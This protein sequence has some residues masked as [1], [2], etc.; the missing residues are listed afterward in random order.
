MSDTP[1]IAQYRAIKKAH[2]DHLLFYRMGDFYELF[3]DDAIQGA[4]LLNITLTHRGQSNGQPIPMAGV[5]YHAAK[6]YFKRLV[7]LGHTFAIC[8]QVGPVQKNSKDPV[9]REVTQ[10][11]TPG[12]VLDEAF[13]ADDQGHILMSV[14]Q[15]HQQYAIATLDL[16]RGLIEYST[17]HG[18]AEL[19]RLLTLYQP[20]EL[21]ISETQPHLSQHGFKATKQPDWFFYPQ[22]NHERIC[23]QF[24]VNQLNAFGLTCAHGAIRVIGALLNYLDLTHQQSPPRIETLRSIQDDAFVRLDEATLKHMVYG[25]GPK[26]QRSLFHYLNQTKTPM[27]GRLLKRWLG[28]PTR[29]PETLCMRQACIQDLMDTSILAYLQ[30]ALINCHDLERCTMRLNKLAITPTECLKLAKT[31]RQLPIII[32]QTM[33]LP[34]MQCMAL[35]AMDDWVKTIEATLYQPEAIDDDFK[36]IIKPG[37]SPELDALR[38]TAA[39]SAFI[40]QYEH[41]QQQ[42]VDNL[43]IK[44][45]YNRIQGY[46]IEIPKSQNI[47]PPSHYIRR[48]TLKNV[49]RY[50]TDELIAFEKDQQSN[51]QKTKALEE[52]LYQSLLSSLASVTPLLRQ[53]ADALAE[54]DVLCAL[55]QR[56]LEGQWCQPQMTDHIGI[57]YEAGTHPVVAAHL[58]QNFIANDLHLVHEQPLAIVT[59]PNMGGK[60]TI[61]RQTALIAILAY[62]GCPVPAKSC[63]IGPIDQIFTRIGAQDDITQGQSTFMVEMQETAYIMRHATEKSLI[64]MDEIGRGTSTFDG[65]SIAYACACHLANQISGLCLF[66][67]HYFELTRLSEQYPNIQNLHVAAIEHEDDLVFLHQLKPGAANKSYGIAVAKLAGLPPATLLVAKEKLH[68][69]E[70][71]TSQQQTASLSTNFIMNELQQ[72]SIDDL[73]PKEAWAYLAQLKQWLVNETV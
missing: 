13:M 55:S 11:I 33:H 39:H 25:D 28:Q 20:S 1:M 24:G 44:V 69:L 43:K 60:S 66:A 59:G 41:E 37:F 31:L 14:Y 56:A 42:L 68:Q 35:T 26:D 36:G 3:F 46:F 9:K 71:G 70:S 63:Q 16:G 17:C 30:Q 62:I 48:Q 61:M 45:G 10:I 67:T 15:Q 4:A 49:E 50:V 29:H 18:E 19:K 54:L 2:E 5:P 32:Q 72:L 12:T 21:I 27:G 57:H 73:S 34:S 51:A 22:A 38:A 47:E 65:L 8:E 58:K 52:S 6:N 40:A 64:L 23:I 53:N 7:N